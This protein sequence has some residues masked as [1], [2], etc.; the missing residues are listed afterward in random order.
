M[1]PKIKLPSKKGTIIIE[2]SKVYEAVLSGE[3]CYRL[4]VGKINKLIEKN[5][6]EFRARV[7]EAGIL[8]EGLYPHSG[9]INHT[10]DYM[11]EAPHQSKRE[12]PWLV[13]FPDKKLAYL[14]ICE[15]RGKNDL[16]WAQP[17]EDKQTGIVFMACNPCIVRDEGLRFLLESGALKRYEA[18][19]MKFDFPLLGDMVRNLKELH[20][21]MVR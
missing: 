18:P 3:Q 15:Y 1:T 11:P 20:K 7:A 2:P 19:G 8:A 6:D 4:P 17:F 10:C 9:C 13:T 14:P 21:Y 12:L 16:R 5:L